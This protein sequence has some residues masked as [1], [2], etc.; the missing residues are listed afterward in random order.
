MLC[1]YNLHGSYLVWKVF[2]KMSSPWHASIFFLASLKALRVS[3]AVVSV[4]DD[5]SP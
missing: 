4:I 2:C 5:G 1:R 3:V